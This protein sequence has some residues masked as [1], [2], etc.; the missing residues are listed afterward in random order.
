MRD[1]A[2]RALEA[3]QVHHEAVEARIDASRWPRLKFPFDVVEIFGGTSQVSIRAA[4]HWDLKVLQPID[5]RYGVDLRR[6]DQR[7]WLRKALAEH[8][9]RLVMIGFPCVS[10]Q[11]LR[12]VSR[13]VRDDPRRTFNDD[14][15]IFQ[16]LV[17]D[18]FKDQRGRGGHG[19]AEWPA[20]F[21]DNAVMNLGGGCCVT[22]DSFRMREHIAHNRHG[23]D[24]TVRFVATHPTL[25]EN[26]LARCQREDNG[27]VYPPSL[28]DAVCR[29][30]LDLVS[31][32]DYG[33]AS[34]WTTTSERAVHYVD[35][36]REEDAWRPLLQQAEELL[37]RKVQASLLVHPDTDL[38]KKVQEL[39]PWQLA[40]VQV[41]H[42]PKAKRVKAGLEECHRASV[43]LLN[44]DTIVI[45][46]EYLK[47][48]QA[49][50]ERFVTPVRY[51][52]FVLGYAPGEPKGPSPVQP[53]PV[54]VLPGDELARDEVQDGLVQEGLVRQ[55]FAGECWFIGGPLREKEKALAR[56]LVRMHR[57]LGHPR[58]EDMVRALA[59]N[60]KVEPDAVSLCRRLRCATCERT[61]RPLPAR[62]TSLK[63]V[64]QFNSKICL[65]FVHVSDAE[66]VTHRYLHV[67]EP[68]GSFNLYYPSKTRQPED[69]FNL[70]CD[71][72]ASWAG[73]PDYIH[74]DRDGAFEGFFL[75]KMK[76]LGVEVEVVP[77]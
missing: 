27:R 38:Y 68:N 48:A 29:A 8:R 66:K 71:I 67:L 19:I 17:V 11:A 25:L 31:I 16:E 3:L 59:Q 60:T 62:P 12:K 54:Q 52:I 69:V 36:K 53:S 72:W 14:V 63:M 51:A 24:R 7:Q 32:E 43:L 47:E 44:D 33:F 9:P 20:D 37:G 34:T 22:Q 42:L 49:P 21:E 35:V 4:H 58:M 28:G 15:R 65:D 45:E 18:V 23:G 2:R 50:R 70:F 26:L 64:G 5:N 1:N 41:A 75:D 74:C 13:E 39:V 30:Y 61:R 76:H 46:T 57:N 77:A 40:V 55:D 6:R 10:W 56:A 73:F